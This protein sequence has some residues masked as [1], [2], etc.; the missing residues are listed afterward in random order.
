MSHLQASVNEQL[1]C[2]KEKSSSTNEVKH[3]YWWFNQ[4]CYINEDCE[5]L[6]WPKRSILC[7]I[8]I[9]LKFSCHERKNKLCTRASK[10]LQFLIEIL[11]GKSAN[12]TYCWDLASSCFWDLPTVIFY[13]HIESFIKRISWKLSLR[14]NIC[15]VLHN[16]WLNHMLTR[17]F[18]DFPFLFFP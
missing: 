14:E 11:K 9:S 5:D 2:W 18:H 16:L 13:K 1:K 3:L 6:K 8:P 4:F 12:K 10:K 17:T 15:H 7:I